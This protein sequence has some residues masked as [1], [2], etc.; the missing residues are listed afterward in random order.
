MSRIRREQRRDFLKQFCA[1]LAGGSALS[2]FPQL[3]L[4]SSA[5]ASTQ[6]DAGY[7]A[8]VCVFLSGGS[9][10][11]NWLVPSDASRYGVYQTARGGV[12]TGTNGPLGLAQASLLSVNMAGSGGVA[13]PAG[14]SYG[15]HPAC[16]DWT[17]IDDNGAQS[18]MPGL[19]SLTNA[20]K[21][22][23]LSNVGT[24]VVPLT[25]ATYSNP[26]LPKPPQLYSHNDQTNLWFQGQETPNFRYGWGGQVADLLFSQNSP[27][28]G[29]SPPLTVPMN[30]SFAGSNRFQ[31]GSQVVPY[32]MSG[33]GDPNG[34]NPFAGSIVGTNF[35]NCSGSNTLDNFRACA[36]AGL[37]A[38]ETALCSLL[39]AN[40]NLLENE[41]ASTMRRAMDLAGQMATKLTGSPNGSLLNTPF[42]ALADNQA[43][44]GYNLAADGGNSLAE[45]LAMVARLIKMR[46][47]LGQTRNIFFVSLGGFDTHA[48][49]MP[50]NGQPRLLRRISR[51]LGSFYQAL[52]EMGVENSVT[53]FTMSEFARTL[54]SNGDGSDHAWGGVQMVMGGAVNGGNAATGR[55]YG[56]FPDQTLNGPDSFSR[57]Q[58]IPTTAMDQ[59]GATL[60]SWMGLGS[61]EVN[62]IFPN[63][64][65]FPSANLGFM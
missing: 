8:L 37:N 28:V 43:V 26:S 42:R 60:A 27:I 49:Q 3:Q 5:L 61:T 11:Y 52:V 9:D 48:A 1:T 57:G 7:K 40:T 53:T 35:A 20:G 29:S 59:M 10:S 32:Q 38:G 2:L 44:A 31:I 17:S 58:M 24:L 22:A 13:L 39:G 16:A 23:W 19:Q 34:G 45:Q 14:H 41:H 51:A 18:S 6:G 63:L 47:Q 15:L 30:I 56:S 36:T 50:D 25:K 62:T 12:Y 65:N 4:M 55:I 21:V 46:T 54:N 64:A 33:C